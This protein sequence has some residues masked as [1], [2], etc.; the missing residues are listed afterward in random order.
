MIKEIQQKIM[1]YDTNPL[2]RIIIYSNINLEPVLKELLWVIVQSGI[3]HP[4]SKKPIIKYINL[5]K[6]ISFGGSIFGSFSH[7]MRFYRN[8]MIPIYLCYS[9]TPIS[10]FSNDNLRDFY[11]EHYYNRKYFS[12]QHLLYTRILFINK[13]FYNSDVYKLFNLFNKTREE[14]YAIRVK[15]NETDKLW[16][17]KLVNE[18]N[19]SLYNKTQI[20]A[21]CLEKNI[22]FN[23]V[24]FDTNKLKILFQEFI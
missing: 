18:D 21:F 23:K 20:I 14:K 16:E 12:F 15:Y 22:P 2:K 11:W 1:S 17:L 5:F 3:G 7:H 24:I 6:K 19:L 9:I 10:Y 4:I 13:N 8:N